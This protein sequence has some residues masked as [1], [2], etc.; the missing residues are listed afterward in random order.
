MDKNK[1]AFA[2]VAAIIGDA[3]NAYL[4]INEKL[5][6]MYWCVGQFISE[7]AK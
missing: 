2:K 4:E 3:K 5:I 1:R 6:N 7:E